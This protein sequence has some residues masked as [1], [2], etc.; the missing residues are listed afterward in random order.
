VIYPLGL[1][2]LPV[3]QFVV[4][5]L[6]RPDIGDIPITGWVIS[7]LIVVIVILGFLW[8][9]RSAAV[10]GGFVSGVYSLMSF[11]WLSSMLDSAF[12]QLTRILNFSSN[13]LEGEG[14]ILW[15]MLSIVLF[16]AIILFRLRS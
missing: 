3:T 10:P 12:N 7:L 6:Y 14:G 2:A 15:V 16:L 11:K 9:R 5:W 13:V 8:Q 1:V 4:G